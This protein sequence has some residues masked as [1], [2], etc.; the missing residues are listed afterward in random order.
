MLTGLLVAEGVTVIHM[1]GLISAHM[2]IGMA[3]IPPAPLKLAST[4][5][6][7]VRYYTG[8]RAYRA[9]G[10]PSFPLRLLVP[11]S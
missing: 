2:F 11:T 4:G 9:K 7:F 8:S 10:P 5:Y 1:G 6:R 3:P